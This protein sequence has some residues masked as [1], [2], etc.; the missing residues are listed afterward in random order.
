MIRSFLL[1]PASGRF[2]GARTRVVLFL[3]GLLLAPSAAWSRLDIEVEFGFSNS[4]A[5][6]AWTPARVVLEN[7]PD[8]KAPS[9][10]DRGF[11]G[12]VRLRVSD[13]RGQPVQYQQEIELPVQSRKRVEFQIMLS[14]SS[15]IVV[16]LVDRKG[17]VVA[18]R[19]ISPPRVSHTYGSLRHGTYVVPTVLLLQSPTETFTLPF[20]LDG[21][22]VSVRPVGADELPSDYRGYDGVRLVAVQGRLNERLKPA[23]LDA[24]DRWIQFGGQLAVVT[25]RHAREIREDA[26]LAERLPGLP[27]G[28]RELTLRDL[29]PDATVTPVLLTRWEQTPEAESV[30]WDT[31]AGPAALLARRGAGA[32]LALGLD[33]SGFGPVELETPIGRHMQALLDVLV[34]G[35]ERDD[36]RA[37]HLWSTADVDPDFKEVMLLPNLWIVTALIVM[38]VVVVGPLNFL[39]LRRRRRLELA[40]ATIPGLS[41]VFFVAVY[42]YGVW[43]K[44]GDQHFA[45]IDVLHAAPGS[46]DALLLSSQIQFAPRK[47]S[48]RFTA[49]AGGVVIPLLQYYEDPTNLNPF[50]FANAF[51]HGTMVATADAGTVASVIQDEA[52]ARRLLAPVE[53]WT[54]QFYQ[55]EAPVELG[56]TLTGAV[57]LIGGDGVELTFHNNTK[58][59]LQE[60]A[61]YLGEDIFPVG[62]VEAGESFTRVLQRGGV[63][64]PRSGPGPLG[65]VPN[66][67]AFAISADFLVRQGAARAY[68]HFRSDN[69][70]R[71]ARFVAWNSEWRNPVAVEPAPDVSKTHGLIELS[72]PVSWEGTRVLTSRSRL[73]R[74]AYSVDS[75][76]TQVEDPTHGAFC[77]LRDSA[78]EVLIGQAW[79]GTQ[80]AF[81]AGTLSFSFTRH[82]EDLVVSAYNYET[83]RWQSVYESARDSAVV[84]EQEHAENLAMDAAWINPLEPMI[85]LRLSAHPHLAPQAGGTGSVF[86]ANHGVSI[87]AVDAIMSLEYRGALSGT[88]PD[89]E[90]G[91]EPAQLNVAEDSSLS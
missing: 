82:T 28:V 20:A 5:A 77:R 42:G 46:S 73:R 19:Q 38:F 4:Y 3:L 55:A 47:E 15:A 41:I 30:F 9:P 7:L 43:A 54:M 69:P 88:V 57:R 65:G 33:P 37:R 60:A 48:Y 26:W 17:V 75:L 58:D 34:L 25:P 1:H 18:Q 89:S 10:D 49:P 86:A 45:S 80:A 2:A 23:Q 90:T 71:A 36:V 35:P 68:P 83:G 13:Y 67:T 16:E 61:L 27:A 8:G 21:P 31:A 76:N 62:R 84:D 64:P 44:G 50:S 11:T 70:Q 81:R 78:V 40:W 63:I 85:R 74:R 79:P 66:R 22:A 72:L 32:I 39:I 59:A 56:G 52:G 29:H 12:H 91:L 87:G 14:T 53:Q 51:A 24:L 6:G